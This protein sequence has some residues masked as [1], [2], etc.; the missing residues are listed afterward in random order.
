M[1]GKKFSFS[2]A[3]KLAGQLFGNI[4]SRDADRQGFEYALYCL[5]DGKKSVQQLV[6]EWIA[7]NEFIDRFII[8][9]GHE[10][11]VATVNRILLGR[12]IDPSL[13]G[14]AVQD[15]VRVGLQ[16]YA[17]DIV[18]SEDY[19]ATIGPNRVPTFQQGVG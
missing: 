19:K 6:I 5:H 2:E 9:F 1:K 12:E 18:A 14:K 8:P 7:S 13:M 4:L 17:C 10:Q 15:F 11:A 3:E 16:K